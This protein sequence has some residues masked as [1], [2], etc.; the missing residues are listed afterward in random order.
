MHGRGRRRLRGACRW[1]ASIMGKYYVFMNA[2]C[3]DDQNLK[4]VRC[5]TFQCRPYHDFWAGTKN[6]PFFMFFSRGIYY[7]FRSSESISE[8]SFF[9]VSS[10][11]LG[12][13][14]GSG[15]N[16][17]LLWECNHWT[18]VRLRR[19]NLQQQP[20]VKVIWFAVRR[21]AFSFL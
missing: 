8:G 17:N 6:R 16:K 1:R 18:K 5:S 4:I 21:H 15:Q 20:L 7:V 11:V 9:T 10:K 14:V 19:D 3:A 12:K 13:V 2:S